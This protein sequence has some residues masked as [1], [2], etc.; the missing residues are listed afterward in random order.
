LA[1]YGRTPTVG[2]DVWLS[3]NTNQATISHATAVIRGIHPVASPIRATGMVGDI[4]GMTFLP[5]LAVFL[6]M[7]GLDALG[8][9]PVAD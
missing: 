5:A 7:P 4:Y 3:R 9:F 6:E 2:V 1:T 8:P